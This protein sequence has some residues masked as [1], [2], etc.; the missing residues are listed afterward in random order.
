MS[1]LALRA[2]MVSGCA[3]ICVSLMLSTLVAGDDWVGLAQ[4]APWI[5]AVLVLPFVLMGYA[6]YLRATGRPLERMSESSAFSDD[7]HSSGRHNSYG[8]YVTSGGV[9]S[10]GRTGFE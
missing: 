5:F 3:W 6:L 2:V 4:V 1:K 9:D 8:E 7:M 10:H